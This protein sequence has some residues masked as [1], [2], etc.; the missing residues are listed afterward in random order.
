LFS[1]H[2]ISVSLV[3]IFLSICASGS[4]PYTNTAGAPETGMNFSCI[5][6][7]GFWSSF[8]NQALL[9]ASKSFCFGINYEDRFNISE[10]GTRT[11][12]LIIPA[13]RTTFGALY[14]N[15]GYRDF[16]RHSLNI[17]CGM[18][19]SGKL[20]GGIQIDYF[21]EKMPGNYQS[22][23][24][25]TFEAGIIV[26]VS[27]S[28]NIGVHIFNP[29]PGSLRSDYLPSSLRTGAGVHLND[30][31]FASAELEAGTDRDLI[32]RTGFDYRAG[33]TFSVRGGFSSENMSFSIGVGFEYRLVTVD[34]GF[35]THEKLG[36]SSSVS[37]IFKINSHLSNRK[38]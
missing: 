13:G 22:C 26:N 1:L 12:A 25:L 18:N 27:G 23:Q 31:L 28:V 34:L 14:S 17:A 38:D 20:L 37:M 3:F 2:K 35:R 11:A 29:V 9:S 15:F 30:A 8:H 4:D 10:L 36:I 32:F 6:K 7:P 5:V 16:M 33:K 24:M 19:L 21:R